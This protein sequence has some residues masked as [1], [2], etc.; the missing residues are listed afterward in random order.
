MIDFEQTRALT[1]AIADE[2]IELNQ[3]SE[4]VLRVA[5]G[6]NLS[7]LLRNVF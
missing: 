6:E 1:R 7:L 2:N 3:T 4:K 5:D